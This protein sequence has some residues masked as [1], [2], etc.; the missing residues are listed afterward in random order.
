MDLYTKESFRPLFASVIVVAFIIFVFVSGV[1]DEI[2][3]SASL[4]RKPAFPDF[5]Q[6]TYMQ[7]LTEEEFPTDARDR[8]VIVVGDIHGMNDSLGNLLRELS[9]DPQADTLIHLGDLVAKHGADGSLPVLSFMSTHNVLGVRGNNDQKVIEWRAWM[10][11]ILSLPGG[12]QWL[13]EMDSSWPHLDGDKQ[14][15]DFDVWLQKSGMDWIDRIPKGWKLLGKHYKTARAMSEEHY[16]YLRSLPLVLYSPMSHTFFVHAGLLP[17]DPN[18]KPT[19]PRQPLS[20]WP[21]MLSANKNTTLLRGLQELALLDDIPQNKDPWT[22]MNMKGVQ[23]DGTIVN[24]SNKGTPWSE[25]WNDMMNRCSGNE[26]RHMVS[27]QRWSP[28]S[29]TPR[30]RHREAT[31]LPCYASTVV[32]GHAAARGLDIK[33]WSVGIDTGCAHDRRLTA[34]VLDRDSSPFTSRDG[35]PEDGTAVEDIST[36]L[37]RIPYGDNGQARLVSINCH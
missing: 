10:H 26:P 15:P 3:L 33:R 22:L 11:W 2:R 13:T 35:V 32:Y 19:H 12:R 23:K 1:A 24:K 28:A 7:T 29:V 34:L 9:Y 6:Y 17:S 18:R 37:S 4:Y 27:M 25:L 5:S 36:H 20:H 30:A 16:D 21:T 8:R 14:N 31:S